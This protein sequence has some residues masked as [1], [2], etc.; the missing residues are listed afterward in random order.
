[1]LD[2]I[3]PVAVSP[4]SVSSHMQRCA[5]IFVLLASYYSTVRVV[6]TQNCNQTTQTNYCPQWELER[7]QKQPIQSSVCAVPLLS[8]NLPF[9]LIL[10][11]I[12]INK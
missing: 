1:M 6:C 7:L 4:S 3:T 2:D 10:P 11:L 5:S 9:K 12:E 8:H